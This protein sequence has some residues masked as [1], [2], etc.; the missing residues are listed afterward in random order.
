MRMTLF[1][2]FEPEST[3]HRAFILAGV[4]A[5]P[6]PFRKL[7]FDAIADE[8]RLGVLRQ[9]GLR[10]HEVVFHSAPLRRPRF[11]HKLEKRGL[12]RAVA[13][14]K[15]MHASTAHLQINPAQHPRRALFIAKHRPA[16]AYAA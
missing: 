15:R 11:G 3:Q 5:S 9:K 16:Y 4:S 13:P 2:P 14:D 8:K 7:L 1:A 12:A 10:A 6:A